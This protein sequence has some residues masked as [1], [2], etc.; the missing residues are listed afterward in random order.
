[1]KEPRFWYYQNIA[2][3]LKTGHTGLYSM[4]FKVQQFCFICLMGSVSTDNTNGAVN[5]LKSF[6]NAFIAE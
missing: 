6:V 5:V 3:Y 4:L 1:M 2:G